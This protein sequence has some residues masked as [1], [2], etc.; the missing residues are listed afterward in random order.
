MVSIL[1]H[2]PHVEEGIATLVTH[3]HGDISNNPQ[4]PR[5]VNGPDALLDFIGAGPSADPTANGR[6]HL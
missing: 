4:F 1:V 3:L 2:G 6:G 5:A